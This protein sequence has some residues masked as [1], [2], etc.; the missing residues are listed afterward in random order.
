MRLLRAMD[1]NGESV[2]VAIWMVVSEDSASIH[3]MV[4]DFKM[5]NQKWPDTAVIMAERDL[6]ERDSLGVIP[7]SCLVDLHVSCHEKFS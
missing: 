2:I 7:K 1:G 6:V 3:K 5:Y 4:E